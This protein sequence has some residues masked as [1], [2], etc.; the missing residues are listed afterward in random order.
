MDIGLTQIDCFSKHKGGSWHL[1]Q[2]FLI[3]WLSNYFFQILDGTQTSRIQHQNR[4]KV[5]DEDG[6]SWQSLN[7]G[8]TWYNQTTIFPLTN[9][10]WQIFTWWS[11]SHLPSY[12]V[13]TS[14]FLLPR[15]PVL[16]F[17][18]FLA[19]SSPGLAGRGSNYIINIDPTKY[20]ERWENY[21]PLK[22]NLKYHIIKIWISK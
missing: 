13:N 4:V 9:L 19:D 11:P 16:C 1:T 7:P 2:Q 3:Y 15:T 21:M 20:R 18:N 12:H 8:V 5:R 14:F 17:V 6:W 10:S 22:W